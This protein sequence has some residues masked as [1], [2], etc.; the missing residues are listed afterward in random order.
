[1]IIFK[2]KMSVIGVIRTACSSL[3]GYI[4]IQYASQP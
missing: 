2:L 1:M 3:K 4:E